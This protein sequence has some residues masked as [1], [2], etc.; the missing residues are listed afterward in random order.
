HKCSAAAACTA[1]MIGSQSAPGCRLTVTKSLTPKM[2]AT[3]G[4]RKTA[5]A[6]ALPAASPGL[7]KFSVAERVTSRPKRRALGFGLG[8]G[9][10][11][12]IR[13]ELARSPRRPSHPG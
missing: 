8:D 9:L 10:A 6:K 1:A 3:P 12:A 7:P 5:S 2:L 11:V 13:I 4:A